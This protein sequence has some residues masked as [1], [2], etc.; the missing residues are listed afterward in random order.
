MKFS[1]RW[2]L[3]FLPPERLPDDESLSALLTARGI[4]VESLESLSSRGLVAGKVCSVRAHSNADKLRVC[5]VDTGEKTNIVCGA[6]NVAEG[7]HVVVAPPGAVV[8]G[9]VMKSREIRGELSAGMICSA[10]EIGA[11]G[12]S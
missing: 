4:E 11:G 5:E 6:P 1:R 12:D 10:A 8:G 7:Q 9:G 2:L 3:D